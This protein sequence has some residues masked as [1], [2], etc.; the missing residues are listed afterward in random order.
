MRRYVFAAIAIALAVGLVACGGPKAFTKGQYGDPEEISMLDDKWNQN[1][2]QLVAKKM[3]GSMEIWA[4]ARA[5][6][7]KP[8]VI[9]EMPRNKTSEHIDMQALYDHV[10]TALIQSGQFTFLDKAARREIAEEYE[11]QGS[12]YVREDEARGPGQQRGA[13]FLLGGVITSTV[14][15]V[16]KDKIIYY[17]ATFELTNIATTEIVWTDQKEITKHFQKKS[18]SF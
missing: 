12:G 18:I 7:E 15:Q 2:M 6:T 17:K 14:Q 3:I 4:N 5:M 16:G 1:D 9:L 10:K 8:P 13:G 11:Y